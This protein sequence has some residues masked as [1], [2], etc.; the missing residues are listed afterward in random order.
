M[1]EKHVEKIFN[2]DFICL[3]AQKAEHFES[4]ICLNIPSLIFTIIKNKEQKI[5]YFSRAKLELYSQEILVPYAIEKKM[6]MSIL[7]S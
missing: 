2:I 6:M 1:F 7:K 4:L 5:D 3:F